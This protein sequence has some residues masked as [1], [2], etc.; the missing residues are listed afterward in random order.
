MRGAGGRASGSIDL[1]SQL[2][3]NP[4]SHRAFAAGTLEPG[5]GRDGLCAALDGVTATL[6]DEQQL[7]GDTEQALEPG[8]AGKLCGHLRQIDPCTARWRPPSRSRVDARCAGRDGLRW[9]A[10]RAWT[11]DRPVVLRAQRVL[12]RAGERVAG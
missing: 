9:P 11:V 4:D 7:A 10:T 5:A 1:A 12:S 2:G 8:R 3:V 6:D